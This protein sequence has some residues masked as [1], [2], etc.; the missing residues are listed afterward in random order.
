[1]V[2]IRQ[3][4]LYNSVIKELNYPFAT[5]FL[6][7]GFIISEINQ[8]VDF[9]WDDHAEQVSQDIASYYGTDGH[10]L[11]LI[12]NRIH[13]Y[14]V[15]P[16]DWFKFFKHNYKLKGYAIVGYGKFTFINAMIENLFFDKKIKRFSDINAALDWATNSYLQ[17]LTV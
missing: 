12:S 8:G 9:S 3:T 16:A 17:T 6:C 15:A 10:D 14:A 5:I 2:S 13:S 1:M 7:D 4:S 11:I